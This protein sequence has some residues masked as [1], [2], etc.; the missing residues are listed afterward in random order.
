MLAAL[1]IA[2]ALPRA[3]FAQ[4][5]GT[6]AGMTVGQL[7]S[8]NGFVPFQGTSSLWNT[9]ISSEPVDSNSDNIMNFIGTSAPLHPDF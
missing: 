3:A 9:D 6:C 5:A 4:A 1:A 2:V 7:T 8:L